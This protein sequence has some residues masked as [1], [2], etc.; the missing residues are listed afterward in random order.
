VC[1]KCFSFIL[2]FILIFDISGISLLN[3]FNFE[4]QGSQFIF[5]RLM[6][7]SSFG[8]DTSLILSSEIFLLINLAELNLLLLVLVVLI[9]NILNFIVNL[10]NL[11]S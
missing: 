5:S 7:N 1:L 10:L 6:G 4:S 9:F 11:D 2:Q 3:S 8:L